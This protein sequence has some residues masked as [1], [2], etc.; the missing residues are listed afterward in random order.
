MVFCRIATSLSVKVGVL[1]M[2]QDHT[3]EKTTEGYLS[4]SLVLVIVYNK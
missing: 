4:L 1:L 3:E 2:P